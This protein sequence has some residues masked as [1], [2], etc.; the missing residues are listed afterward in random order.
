MS[1]HSHN[2]DL[3]E[4]LR[5]ALTRQHAAHQ[6]YLV[7]EITAREKRRAWRERVKLVEEIQEEI[8]TGRTGRRV[9]AQ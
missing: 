5:E 4:E 3:V 9:A 8:L 6:D 1:S 7:A 2:D